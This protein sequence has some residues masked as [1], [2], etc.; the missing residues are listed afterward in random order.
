MTPE[1]RPGVLGARV[2]AAAVLAAATVFSGGVAAA[3]P[4]GD[5]GT[6]KIHD[7]ETPAEDPKNEP[8]V[9]TFYIK[10]DNFDS[11][12]EVSWEIVYQSG[13][14]K[15]DLV[16]AGE[17]VLDQDGHGT[18]QLI[19]LDEGHYKLTWTFEGENG[20]GKHKVFKV[21]CEDESTEEP[22]DGPS[23]DPSDEPSDDP[24]GDPSDEPS[25]DPS[26]DPSTDPSGD[27]GDD[28][29][30]DPFTGP[31]DDPSEPADEGSLPVTGSALAGLVAAGAVAVAGGGAA[32]YLG[33]RK[34]TGNTQG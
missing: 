12:Q 14:D 29:S 16:L 19:G 8:K 11:V 6:V 18:S 27:P 13:P 23:E 28:P 34:G 7:P 25:D 3:A 2:L 4:P 17:L 32:L 9:C 1:P 31:S 33:R 10:G 15:D 26:D 21:E 20:A 30:T 22:S 5:N 24:S